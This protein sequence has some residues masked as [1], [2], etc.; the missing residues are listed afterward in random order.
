VIDSSGM[1]V[2]RDCRFDFRTS[3]TLMKSLRS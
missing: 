3:A 2:A 1:H